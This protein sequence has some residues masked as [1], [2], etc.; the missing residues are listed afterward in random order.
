MLPARTPWPLLTVQ[1]QPEKQGQ[2]KARPRAG[3]KANYAHLEPSHYFVPTAVETLGALGL[4]ALS[5]TY[6]LGRYIMDAT[7][8]PLSHHYL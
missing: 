8:E 7:Q 5:F 1:L 2:R 6:N 4:Q 3:K